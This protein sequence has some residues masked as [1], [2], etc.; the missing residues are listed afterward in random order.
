MDFITGLP[1]YKNPARGPDFNII[2][3]VINRYS[4]IARYITCHKT[5]NSPE[6]AKII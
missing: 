2:L 1:P 3:V 6:L 5:I 4:K